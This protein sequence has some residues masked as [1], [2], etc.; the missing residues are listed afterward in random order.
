MPIFRR[1]TNTPAIM[2]RSDFC[3][4][5]FSTMDAMVSASYGVLVRQRRIALAQA[6]A[7]RVSIM[8]WACL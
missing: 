6:S 5:S 8:A 4:V 2:A 3:P 7:R 1:L